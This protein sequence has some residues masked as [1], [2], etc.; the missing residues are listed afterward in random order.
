MYDFVRLP[1]DSAFSS[2]AVSTGSITA[3]IRQVPNQ[4]IRFWV[5]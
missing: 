2:L 1:T 3:V 4:P 5:C